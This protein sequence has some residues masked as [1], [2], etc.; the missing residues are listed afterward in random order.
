MQR[1]NVLVASADVLS[2]DLV[3]ACILGH[4]PDRVPHLLHA[5]R[6]RGRP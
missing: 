1:S 4:S 2:A 5:A 3:G 6:N